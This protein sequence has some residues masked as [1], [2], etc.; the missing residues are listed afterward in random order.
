MDGEETVTEKLEK[1]SRLILVADNEKLQE[2]IE[3][4]AVNQDEVAELEHE[5]EE[6]AELDE[7][8]VKQMG[9]VELMTIVGSK[10]LSADHVII[11]GFDNVNMN[12]V[13]KN[14]F[15]VAMTRARKSLHIMTALKSGGAGQAHSFL[16]QLSDE[17]T[18]F[19]SYKKSDRSKNPLQ[20]R[21]GFKNYLNKLSSVSAR[22]R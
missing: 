11:I 20:G 14:A 1:I 5:K 17:H 4:K 6:Q 19:I 12:W 10:G 13:T 16:D 7:I 8:E 15:Y 22:R 18:E 3:Q 2:D 9:A 21:Q